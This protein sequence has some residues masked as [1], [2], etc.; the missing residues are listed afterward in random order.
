M[1]PKE[2]LTEVHLEDRPYGK[3]EGRVSDL[4][5]PMW[6]LG[7]QTEALTEEALRKQMAP[8]KHDKE[9]QS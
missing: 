4:F 1:A 3:L 2:L 8:S 9:R 6:L 5:S 7:S